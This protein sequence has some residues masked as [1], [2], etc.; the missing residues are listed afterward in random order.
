MPA[1]SSQGPV[2][3]RGSRPPECGPA[4]ALVPRGRRPPSPRPP[5]HRL[6]RRARS[7]DAG[8]GGTAASWPG[9]PKKGWSAKWARRPRGGQPC[10]PGHAGFSGCCHQRCPPVLVRWDLVP[11][12]RSCTV[13]IPVYRWS[14]PVQTG[15]KNAER[16]RS[17]SEV[18]TPQLDPVIEPKP[19]SVR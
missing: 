19:P 2:A 12:D 14:T 6:R 15:E 5:A 11:P 7:P 16:F 1:A 13:Q 8:R 4:P 10:S 3:R 17:G 9:Q 18:G